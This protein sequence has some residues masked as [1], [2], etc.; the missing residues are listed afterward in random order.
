MIYINLLTWV[1]FGLIGYVPYTLHKTNIVYGILRILL[2]F[3]SSALDVIQDL[4]IFFIYVS[5]ILI[6]VRLNRIINQAI[7]G[8]RLVLVA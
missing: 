8:G 7:P 1:G 2:L 4:V 6:W 3:Y 5:D